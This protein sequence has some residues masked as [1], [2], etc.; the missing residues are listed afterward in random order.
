MSNPVV[1]PNVAMAHDL[2]SEAAGAAAGAAAAGAG[3][4]AGG[5]SPAEIRA[6]IEQ[7]RADLGS[8]ANELLAEFS[9]GA[10]AGRAKQAAGDLVSDAV[11]ADAEPQRQ[12]R[13]R[14]ILAGAGA[15]V[16]LGIVALIRGRKS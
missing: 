8:V 4:R 6:E 11:S 7:L 3:E 15:A 9:P 12:Q 2:S 5:G 1:G 14:L 10:L 16:T 13:A